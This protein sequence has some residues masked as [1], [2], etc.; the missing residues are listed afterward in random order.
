MKCIQPRQDMNLSHRVYFLPWSPS[1]H[2]RSEDFISKMLTVCWNYFFF[3]TK[4]V[5]LCIFSGADWSGSCWLVDDDHH[6]E[7]GPT[8]WVPWTLTHHLVQIYAF[9]GQASRVC[10]CVWVHKGT[11]LIN[12]SL[13]LHPCSAPSIYRCTNKYCL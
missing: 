11:S 7:A 13:L 10:P 9:T 5:V 6:L 12:S 4:N 3:S 1:K 2:K 8:V